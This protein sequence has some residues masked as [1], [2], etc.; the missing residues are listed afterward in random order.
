M[1]MMSAFN[2]LVNGVL[3][4]PI[5]KKFDNK[6]LVVIKYCLLGM[7]I[8]YGVQF[9]C[10]DSKSAVPNAWRGLNPYFGNCVVLS[11]FQY[12]LATCITAESS[13]RVTAH[14]KGTLLGLEHSLFAAARIVT[15][16]V[17]VFVLSEYGVSGVSGLCG[18]V[19]LSLFSFW[20]IL[21][22]SASASGPACVGEKKEA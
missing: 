12:I 9:V 11:M 15:P 21:D 17:G 1:A 10:T 5:V 6:L 14:A 18:V 3:L 7:F 8:F 13:A 22:T 4:A 20:S 19:F 2:A 16:Q